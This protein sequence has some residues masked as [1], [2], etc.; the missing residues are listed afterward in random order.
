MNRTDTE[1]GPNMLIQSA[2]KKRSVVSCILYS[3]VLYGGS[4]RLD[5][6]RAGLC[7]E[8]SKLGPSGSP[9]VT[10]GRLQVF[11]HTRAGVVLS[12]YLL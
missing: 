1:L 8:S 6:F 2:L 12:C 4:L 11:I 5:I 10:V 9:E 3:S 7:K